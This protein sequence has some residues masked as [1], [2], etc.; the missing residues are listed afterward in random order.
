MTGWTWDQTRDQLD[1]PRCEAL[2]EA[3]GHNPPLAL[4]MRAAAEALGVEFKGSQI[5][6]EP[7]QAFKDGPSIA[8]M[9]MMAVPL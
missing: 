8:E 1:I 9:A 2:R 6:S 7:T 3:W 5:T 4:T